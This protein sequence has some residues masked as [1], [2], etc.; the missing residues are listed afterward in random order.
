MQTN[1]VCSICGALGHSKFYCKS[2]PIKSIAKVRKKPRLVKP[3]TKTKSR[4]QL[5]KELDSVF[6]KYIRQRDEGNGCITCGDVKP[7]KEMQNC[8]FYTRG[9]I[10]TRWDEVNCHSGCYRCNVILK[11][12]Y[13]NYTRYMIDRFG[14]DA[15]D[16]LETKSMSNIKITT[17][18]IRDMIETYKKKVTK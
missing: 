7:W 6:S 5:V 1:K 3:R 17:E 18:E 14:R 8:H 12:N 10:P 11:G 15:V 16:E 4:S 2:K 13:I 9:R